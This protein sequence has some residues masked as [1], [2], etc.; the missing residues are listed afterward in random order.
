MTVSIPMGSNLTFNDNVSDK[1][2]GSF[3]HV[4][5]NF[6]YEECWNTIVSS[7]LENVLQGKESSLTLGLRKCI[8]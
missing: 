5:N 7:L 8:E 2:S 4:E 3:T 1:A 6:H